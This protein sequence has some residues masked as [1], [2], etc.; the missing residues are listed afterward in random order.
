MWAPIAVVTARANDLRLG[1][2]RRH[3]PRDLPFR[4][5]LTYQPLPLNPLIARPMYE[6]LRRPPS[7]NSVPGSL[8]VLFFGNLFTARVATV[9]LNPSHQEYLDP[10]GNELDGTQRRFET[11]GSLR[12]LD[13]G[14][15][16]DEQCDRAISTMM[17][18]FQ[19]GKPVYSWFCALDRVAKGIGVHY[20]L[21]EVVHLDLVQEATKPA[22]S[23]L[24][25]HELAQLR[26]VDEPFLRW[27]L[28]SFPLNLVICNGRTVFDGVQALTNARLLE[29]GTFARVTWFIAMAELPGK[30]MA[31]VGWN[32][33]LARPTGLAKE[34]HSDLGRLLIERL[35]DGC[36]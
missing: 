36:H 15:L 2:C 21:G 23:R 17:A 26:A 18:Y 29:S 30:S 32:I 13:R 20:E 28:E 1:R 35:P 3:P 31:V 11:L 12:A 4:P 6:R 5:A 25:P 24:D 8:P 33:P 14:S 27:Q 19:P 9:G 16:T 34:G 22:W 7:A 10:R